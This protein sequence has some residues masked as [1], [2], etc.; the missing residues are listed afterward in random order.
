MREAIR[1]R[2]VAALVGRGLSE[3][4]AWER[5]EAQLDDAMAHVERAARAVEDDERDEAG[6]AADHPAH[7]RVRSFLADRYALRALDKWIAR[8]L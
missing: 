6:L 1:S 8:K 5:A 3:A 4:A 7:A 2:I